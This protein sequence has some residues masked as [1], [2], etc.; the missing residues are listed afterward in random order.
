[1]KF[2]KITTALIFTACLA[3]FGVQAA[4]EPSQGSGKI[5]FTGSIIEA[6]CSINPDSTN[7]E[8]DLGQ[9]AK[10][11]LK[12][13]GQSTPR[14][15]DI[16]LENCSFEEESPVGPGED[17]RALVG[18]TVK[19]T[20]GGS[21]AAGSAGPINT[22]LGIT[23]TAKGAGVAITDGSGTVIE[24]NKESNGRELINGDNTLNFSAYLQGIDDASLAT[25]EFTAV[26]NFTLSYM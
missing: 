13:N 22:L 11:Q 7:Q 12:D 23:G 20:F 17:T 1:M 10:S 25:G 9:I 24:L 3:T 6:A 8:I 19:I 2:N 15:F 16:L 14:N 4:S 21:P 18:N 5:T 26:T